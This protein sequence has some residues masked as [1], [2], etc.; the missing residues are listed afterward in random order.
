VAVVVIVV[1]VVVVVLVACFAAASA[2][3]VAVGDKEGCASKEA[4]FRIAA[5]T[6]GFCAFD[7]VPSESGAAV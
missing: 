6:T 4:V 2:A 3:V 1:A 7:L 5:A